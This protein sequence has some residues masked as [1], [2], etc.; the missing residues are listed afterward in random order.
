M[1]K[2]LILSAIAVPGAA[3]AQTS[4]TNCYGF[5]SSVQ[6]TTT[7][8]AQQQEQMNQAFRNL[9]AAIAA[10]RERKQAEKAAQEAQAHLEAVKAA[11]QR[12]L[13][14]DNAPA[15]PP[16]SDE[17][18]VMLVCTINNS[19]ASIALYEKHNR[20]DVTSG[21]VTHTRMATFTTEAV[22]WT[23]PLLRN[24]LSRV[25]GSYT[26]YGNIPEVEGQSITGN[27]KLASAR[28]F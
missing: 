18:A 8:N 4:T 14:S 24:S 7:N 20:A 3:H 1:R 28:A 25:D 10:R 17:Q 23:T 2:W 22:T 13:D 11:I 19:P 16:P 21:G 12:A 5:G 26:G 9:G 27:C 15:A 6:C